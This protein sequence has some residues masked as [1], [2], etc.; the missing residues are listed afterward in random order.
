MPPRSALPRQRSGTLT[1]NGASTYT[2]ANQPS[3]PERLLVNGV[4]TGRRRP[5]RHRARW[6]ERATA[7]KSPVAA[8]SLRDP[9]S[10]GAAHRRQLGRSVAQRSIYRSAAGTQDRVVVSVPNG[11]TT[12]GAANLNVT[13]TGA[14]FGRYVLLDYVGTPLANLSAF[15]PGSFTVAGVNSSL[16]NNTLN[17]SVDLYVPNPSE[18]DS[19]WGVAGSGT[20][21]VGSNWTNA[22]A[23]NGLDNVATFGTVLSSGIGTVTLGTPQTVALVNF[24]SAGSY[25]LQGNTLT[26][27]TPAADMSA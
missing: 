22:I 5:Q 7:T 23:P 16:V 18:V 2:G 25:V 11:L 4:H 1:F 27:T 24:N 17:T 8:K 21:D 15:A 20:W 6:A 9:D 14:S 12:P 3:S 10:I 13:D 26:L 19:Q